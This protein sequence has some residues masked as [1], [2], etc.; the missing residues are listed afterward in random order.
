MI[1]SQDVADVLIEEIELYVENIKLEPPPEPPPTPEEKMAQMLAS[2]P[3]PDRHTIAAGV[4]EVF[5]AS[6]LTEEGRPCR[7]RLLYVPRQQSMRRAVHQLAVPAALTRAILRKLTPAQGRLG[8]LTWDCVS[9]TPEITGVQAREGGDPSDLTIAAPMNGALDINWMSSRLVTVR[10]GRIERHSRNL[11]PQT[12]SA[13]H[14][15]SALL[16]SFEPVFLNRTIRAIA[17]ASHGGAIWILRKDVVPDSVQIEY[18]VQPDERPLPT[19]ANARFQILESI[20]HLAAVDGAV[21]LDQHIKILGFG[22]FI[23]IPDE[24]KLVTTISDENKEEKVLST[25]L[26]GGR[27]RSAV[28]FCARFAPA[29]AIV[30]SEDGRISILWSVNADI[31][32]CAPLSTVGI[33]SDSIIS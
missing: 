26:G 10:A 2:H 33:L 20:G 29:A 8:Y 32:F 25:K 13:F 7:P 27:H 14:G 24:P 18:H 15:V 6:L 31:L 9:G 30:V 17:D 16:G 11:K 19:Q 22:A 3:L 4:E 5:W 23:E 1:N 12:L 21:V 28:E